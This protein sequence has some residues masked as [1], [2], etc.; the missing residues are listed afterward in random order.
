[1]QFAP[2]QLWLQVPAV[3]EVA[4]AAETGSRSLLDLQCRRA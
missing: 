2:Q 3:A 4:A 1:M